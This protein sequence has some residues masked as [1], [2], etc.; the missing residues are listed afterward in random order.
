[1]FA[2]IIMYYHKGPQGNTQHSKWAREGESS[3]SRHCS[4]FWGCLELF[5]KNQ[6]CGLY[7][8][9]FC[10]FSFGPS[11]LC[12]RSQKVDKRHCR[13]LRPFGVPEQVVLGCFELVLTHVSPC[14]FRKRYSKEPFWVPKKGQ[15]GS[16]TS[17]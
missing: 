10:K 12:N 2:F 11:N 4:S 7:M 13:M 16:E 8:F 3:K 1:M 9:N 6:I 15:K 17:L 14:K 5:I